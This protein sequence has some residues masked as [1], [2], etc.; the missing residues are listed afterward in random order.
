MDDPTP[1]G[2]G[3]LPRRSGTDRVRLAL[4]VDDES[5]TRHALMRILTDLGFGCVEAD[6]A[7]EALSLLADCTPCIGV[8]DIAM[9]GM[10]GAELAWRI[11]QGSATFPLIAVSG[12]L[13]VWDEDDLRDLGFDYVLSKPFDVADF[14][15][16]CERAVDDAR[17]RRPAE[18]P[19]DNAT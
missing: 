12:N 13:H 11:R 14:V 3:A 16:T 5:Q 9:P 18:L 7:E 6:T 19:G 8:F 1:T 15:A 4:V 2:D 10:G 17:Q